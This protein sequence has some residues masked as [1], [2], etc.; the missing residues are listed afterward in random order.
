[1]PSFIELFSTQLKQKCVFL[2]PQ[3]HVWPPDPP[4]IS[5]KPYADHLGALNGHRP[6]AI[7][8]EKIIKQQNLY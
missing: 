3:G 8:V 1:M 2:I 6:G 5:Q 4:N 7:V